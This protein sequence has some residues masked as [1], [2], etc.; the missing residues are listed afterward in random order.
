MTHPTI[1][2]QARVVLLTMLLAASLL[3]V[4]S[5]VA[6]AQGSSSA[7]DAAV[8]YLEAVPG[9][10]SQVQNLTITLDPRGDASKDGD[11]VWA[12]VGG[13][14]LNKKLRRWFD[15]LAKGPIG[16]GKVP[17]QGAIVLATFT[18]LARK[19]DLKGDDSVHQYNIFG[20][21]GAV[22]QGPEQDPFETATRVDAFGTWHQEGVGTYPQATSSTAAGGVVNWFDRAYVGAGGVDRN[23][24]ANV[25]RL[26]DVPFGG[27]GGGGNP[28]G[29]GGGGNPPGGNNPPGG[30]G[31]PPGGGGNGAGPDAGAGVADDEAGGA[32][33]LVDLTPTM[34]ILVESGDSRDAITWFAGTSFFNSNFVLGNDGE[35]CFNTV[36]TRLPDG[37]LLIEVNAQSGR[38][39]DL[40]SLHDFMWM[41]SYATGG[42]LLNSIRGEW[43]RNGTSGMYRGVFILPIPARQLG[44]VRIAPDERA[45]VAAEERGGT[46]AED[47]A[48]VVGQMALALATSGVAVPGFNG[49]PECGTFTANDLDICDQRIVDAVQ[50]AMAS[51]GASL[52][53]PLAAVPGRAANGARQCTMT[54]DGKPAAQVTA[55]GTPVAAENLDIVAEASGCDVADVGTERPARVLDCDLFTALLWVADADL[56]EDIESLDLEEEDETALKLLAWQALF[57]EGY[58]PVIPPLDAPIE[59]EGMGPI[60]NAL[61]DA[62]GEASEGKVWTPA[63]PPSSANA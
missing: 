53:G 13:V 48:A 62:A 21:G 63:Y 20:D 12:A 27:G 46:E 40:E 3:P 54:D 58:G 1:A 15:K 29:G 37:R 35:A 4:T 30:G 14:T 22:T 28:P 43:S 18:G 23:V 50:E 42:E 57:A 51:A 38:P 47:L 2:R 52:A 8:K 44:S 34:Q 33:P 7:F 6:S 36:S 9:L 59:M 26:E 39:L 41:S 56:A 31:N 16:W 10:R 19:T 61:M 55:T 45:L 49:N 32:V 11:A 25:V 24:I 5:G 60:A 17:E